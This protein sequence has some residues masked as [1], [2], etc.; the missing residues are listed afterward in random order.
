MDEAL[1]AGAASVQFSTPVPTYVENFL[2]MP[3]G[4]AVPA[5]A[6]DPSVG[7]W[8]PM[9][10]GLV[11]AITAI[12]AGLADLDTDGDGAADTTL[13]LTG[14][15]ITSAERAT[16]ASLYAPGQTLWRV[17]LK[18]FTAVSYSWPTTSTGQSQ[19]GARWRP[20]AILLHVVR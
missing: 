6:Y 16:L 11:I 2:G 7:I 8:N 5:G 15:G 10:N 9:D 12:N 13:A 4:T 18:H 17:P 19:P 20:A 1:S 3:V 14:L